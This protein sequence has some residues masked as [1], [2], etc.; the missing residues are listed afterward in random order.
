MTDEQPVGAEE[1]GE[2]CLCHSCNPGVYCSNCH[3]YLYG[4]GETLC[5]YCQEQVRNL[6]TT[7]GE[8]IFGDTLITGPN[9]QE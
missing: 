9:A 4:S 6:Q 7:Q 5:S 8:A 1:H 3:D 2:H